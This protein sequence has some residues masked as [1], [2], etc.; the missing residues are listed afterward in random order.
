MMDIKNAMEYEQYA[1]PISLATH[2]NNFS[3]KSDLLAE[4]TNG[5][6]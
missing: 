3:T 2:T 6:E 5:S 4:R 1:S